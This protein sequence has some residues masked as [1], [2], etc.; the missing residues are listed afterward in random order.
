MTITPE[1]PVRAPAQG[2]TPPGPSDR[3]RTQ[4]PG[5]RAGGA[6]LVLVALVIFRLLWQ[7]RFTSYVRPGMGLPLAITGF[8]LA[9][10]GAWGLV[11]PVPS[12][13]TPHPDDPDDAPDGHAGHGHSPL[14][15]ICWLLAVPVLVLTVIAPGPL[16][17]SNSADA[18][19]AQVPFHATA[20]HPDGQGVIT[21]KLRDLLGWTTEDPHKRLLNH[22]VRLVGMAASVTHDGR[23]VRLTRFTITCCAADATPFSA[24]VTLPADSL[25][26]SKG[27]WLEVVGSWNG[28]HTSDGWPVI[29]GATVQSIAQP[30]EPYEL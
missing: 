30:A 11:G 19:P 6:L 18:A 24:D 22:P 2:D 9:V 28:R 8:M 27:G 15:R 23:L 25:V 4:T 26:P 21:M 12:S 29:D 1:A 7:G 16:G 20:L 17:A 3:R 5:V 10:V 14:P 13:Q